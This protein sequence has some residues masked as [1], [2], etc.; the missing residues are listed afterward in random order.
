MVAQ[1]EVHL[2]NFTGPFD[3]LL[4]LISK[5]KMDVTEIALH[6][7][8][9]DFIAFTRQNAARSDFDTLTH[10]LIVAATLLEIK[11]ARLLPGKH[12]LDEEDLAILETRDLLFARLLEYQAVKDIAQ[13]FIQFERNAPKSYPR[14]VSLEEQFTHIEPPLE[15]GIDSFGLA[16]IA[17]E[18]FSRDTQPQVQI[19]HIHSVQVSVEYEAAR[20]MRMLCNTQGSIL[21]TDLVA[22]SS[23]ALEVVASFLA[24]LE[25]YRDNYV[26]VQ[27]EHALDPLSLVWTGKTFEPQGETSSPEVQ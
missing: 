1:F 12:E 20:M 22:S 17:Q 9:D 15:L 13:I 8:T 16:A 21:F 2:S 19:E 7:V 5:R 3:L 4:E 11:S 27:Q 26:N 10:F 6:A 24:I 25:L 18:V 14:L 23:H